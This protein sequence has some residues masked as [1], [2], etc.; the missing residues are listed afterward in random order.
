MASSLIAL[1]LFHVYRRF[2]VAA[3]LVYTVTKII[4]FVWRWRL[5]T[6]AGPKSKR[7]LYRYVEVQLLRARLSRFGGDIVQIG[8]LAAILVWVVSVQL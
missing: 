1:T 7:L 8:V 6:S 4:D 3:V 2:V 5:V